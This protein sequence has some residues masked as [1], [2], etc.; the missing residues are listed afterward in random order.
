MIV[1]ICQH[2]GEQ[3]FRNTVTCSCAPYTIFSVAKLDFCIRA[4]LLDHILALEKKILVPLAYIL[5]PFPLVSVFDMYRCLPQLTDQ[6]RISFV[7]E[8]WL[9]DST[10]ATQLQLSTSEYL[11]NRNCLVSLVKMSHI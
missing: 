6:L 1:F 2:F 4:L 7:I 8:S 5:L 9:N 3:Q 11:I 10:T